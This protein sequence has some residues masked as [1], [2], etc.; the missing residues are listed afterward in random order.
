LAV[1]TS[2]R[3]SALPD[4]PTLREAGIADAEYPFWVGLFVPAKTPRAIVDKLH[5]ET[6]KA[7]QTPK[8]REKLAAMGVEPMNAAPAE[9]DALV[10]SEI[11][12]NAALVKSIGLKPAQ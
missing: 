6:L 8:V 3:S 5:S 9:F 7:L 11:P 10:A 2:R 1:N 4:V 12:L